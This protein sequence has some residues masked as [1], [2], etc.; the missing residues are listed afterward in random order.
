MKMADLLDTDFSL[1]GVFN[2]LGLNLGFGESTVAEVCGKAGI[3]PDT[4]LIICRV[5][6]C[7]GYMPS[8]EALAAAH[9]GDILTYLR[10][11][12][13][14]YLESMLPALAS[15]LEKAVAPCDKSQQH[16]IRQFFTDYKEELTKHFAYEENTVFPY[17]EAML[18]SEDEGQ[19]TID[20]YEQ[21]HTNVQEK[22]S[23]L[24]NLLMMYLPEHANIRDANLA[25]FYLFHLEQD[26]RKHTL[27]EDDILVPVVGR[28]EETVAAAKPEGEELSAREKE[29]LVSVAQGLLNKEIADKYN[30]SIYTVITHRKNITRKTGIKTVAGLTVYALLNNLIT[31]E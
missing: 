12:H 6:T 9:L 22:L 25:L 28:L 14:Y 26:L 21:N 19:Y 8:P 31:I 4:F 11:S 2:R 16:I 20:E 7:E 13:S 10:T 29:I 1:L 24:K 3:D 5:Y 23:D 27:I 17:V 18:N 15:S 30:I